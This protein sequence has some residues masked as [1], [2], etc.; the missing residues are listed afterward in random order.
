MEFLAGDSEVVLLVAFAGWRSTPSAP[1]APGQGE[2]QSELQQGPWPHFP[3]DLQCYFI[4][5][6]CHHILSALLLTLE[7]TGVPE[8][9]GGRRRAPRGCDLI[10]GEHAGEGEGEALKCSACLG[11]SPS[12]QACLRLAVSIAAPSV[13]RHPA[14]VPMPSPPCQPLVLS[15]V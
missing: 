3:R 7:E 14:S 10:A 13:P 5:A 15:K 11:N 1:Q 12:K 9:K 2:Q 8:G 6:R 4:V